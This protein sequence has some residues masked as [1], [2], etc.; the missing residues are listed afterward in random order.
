MLHNVKGPSSY[1]ELKTVNGKVLNYQEA[2][3]ARYLIFDDSE[4]YGC[5]TEASISCSPSMLRT[6]YCL[7]LIHND[8][9]NPLK[10]FETFKKKLSE[11]Y[12]YK[13]KM[14]EK[15][16]YEHAYKM[17]AI[18]INLLATYGRNF[19]WFVNNRSLPDV[20]LDL[21]DLYSTDPGKCKDFKGGYFYV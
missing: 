5:L 11:D 9:G 6:L 8:P 19:D 2:C 15:E 12:I 18:K 4:W 14:K 7:I 3:L 1:E 17:I 10:L 21:K 20:K 16:A 13:E